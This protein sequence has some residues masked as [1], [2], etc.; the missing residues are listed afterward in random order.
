MNKITHGFT[1]M[2]LMITLAIVAILAAVAFPS[3]QDSIRRT[4]RADAKAVMLEA[5]QFMERLYTANS[6][7]D[8]P[9]CGSN[10]A[11]ALP[12][13]LTTIPRNEA[14]AA[15]RFY[16]ITLG[17]VTRTTY[18]LTATPQNAQVYD[19]CAVLT[20]NNNSVRGAAGR[21]ANDPLTIECWGR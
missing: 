12:V 5:A 19:Q 16:T 10:A 18:T 11:P 21:P 6:C 17:G 1:L 4:R 2:E 8:V 15:N 13:G 3:Y 14:N 9:P 20:L 7:F